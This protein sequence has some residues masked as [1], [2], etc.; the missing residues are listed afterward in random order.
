MK[1]IEIYLFYFITTV[2]LS[3]KTSKPQYIF[4]EYNNLITS[5]Q[6]ITKKDNENLELRVYEIDTAIIARFNKK[7][8][9]G[10][11]ST[12]E[13][14]TIKNELQKISSR[15]IDSTKTIIINFFYKDNPEPN[16]SCIDYYVNDKNYKKYFTKN[17]NVLQ[18]F[19]TEKDYKYKN[20]NVLQDTNDVIK[21][22]L[23]RYK[24]DCGN[25]IIIKSN[26]TFFRKLGEY[27]QDEII[28]NINHFN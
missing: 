22:V 20:N 1:K 9:I 25:Y 23:F 2:C 24:F 21:K 6:F 14:N 27:R 8:D 7:I 13:T 10:M 15:K 4:D 18:F 12:L 17:N 26:G 16:G 11:L 28:K 19:I 5:G 3:Q